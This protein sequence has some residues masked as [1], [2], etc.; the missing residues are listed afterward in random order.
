[1][2][3][4]DNEHAYLNALMLAI[5][6]SNEKKSLECMKMAASIEPKLTE[7]QIDLCKK[8]IEV[9]IEFLKQN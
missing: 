6:A 4:T 9:C 2:K 3:I 8:G 1:M 7:K 5:T